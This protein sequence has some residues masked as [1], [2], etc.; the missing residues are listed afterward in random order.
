MPHNLRAEKPRTVG[1][2]EARAK[3]EED[4]AEALDRECLVATDGAGGA[5]GSRS[6]RHRSVGAGAVVVS[7]GPDRMPM[8]ATC[9]RMKVPGRQTVPR[10]ET[11][12]VLP[13]LKVMKR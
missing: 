1:E 8:H 3:A 5:V 9:M 10:A 13:V 2:A 12:A 7:F 4:F 11:W 6:E